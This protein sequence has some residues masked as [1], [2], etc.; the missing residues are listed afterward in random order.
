M[1]KDDF[2][3]ATLF[4]TNLTLSLLTSKKGKVSLNKSAAKE[5]SIVPQTHDREKKKRVETDQPYLK[6]LGITNGQDQVIPKMADKYRQIN[7][8]SG[9]LGTAVNVCSMVFCNMGSDCVTGVAFTRDGSGGKA[10]PI[11]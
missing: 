4:T 10:V 8:I 11:G 6:Y 2:K 5:E 3:N 9:L 7:K 1:L